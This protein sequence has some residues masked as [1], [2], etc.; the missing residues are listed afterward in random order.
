M[1][2]KYI[3][4]ILLFSWYFT[5]NAQ[6]WQRE[7]ITEQYNTLHLFHSTQSFNL[8]TTEFMQK[9]DFEFEISHR[10][11]PTIKSGSRDL[12]GFDGPV[13]IRFG[14]G[15]ALLDD[16][17]ITVGRSNKEDNF[18]FTVKQKLFDIDNKIAP[19]NFAVKG[20]FAW[21]TEK[22]GSS[23]KNMNKPQ[24]FVQGIFN[25]LYNNKFGLGIVPTYLYNNSIYCSNN[26]HSFT[27]G[28]YGQVYL[29]R[30]F[31][32][33][34]EINSTVTGWRK[35]HNSVSLGGEL[36]TGGHFFKVFLTNNTSLNTSQ[37]IAGADNSFNSGEL[38]IAFYISRIL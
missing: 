10:F 31:S 38:S 12:W 6:Q 36:E 14:L 23:G 2:I 18:D 16:L 9:G 22:L 27:I 24:Y 17:I 5:L 37:F 28:G 35:T 20:G 11:I 34:A 25:L 7:E 1:K 33:L 32:I 4:Y 3:L 8:P 29:S 30:M 21:N 26:S 15:Y 13:N 19:F